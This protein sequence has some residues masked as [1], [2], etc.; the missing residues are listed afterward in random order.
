MVQCGRGGAAEK[1]RLQTPQRALQRVDG[2]MMG[3]AG[4]GEGRPVI[5]CPSRSRDK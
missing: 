4:V 5:C 3:G 2:G 1:D